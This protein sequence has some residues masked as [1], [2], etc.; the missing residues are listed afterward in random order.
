MKKFRQ[1]LTDKNST[2][3]KGVNNHLSLN[4]FNSFSFHIK[5]LDNK[6]ASETLPGR[7]GTKRNRIICSS[8][9]ECAC[10]II[11]CVAVRSRTRGLEHLRINRWFTR[12]GCAVRATTTIFGT[13]ERL[14]RTLASITIP[15]PELRWAL[16]V[17]V[18]R[19]PGRSTKTGPATAFNDHGN[20]VAINKADV[21]KILP[22][23]SKSELSQSYRRCSSESV[24]FHLT[25]P[26]VTC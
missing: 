24:A 15:N 9:S 13:P 5:S 20:I 11:V 23:C 19:T 1:N 22:S 17:Q 2:D 14:T 10:S 26:T 18:S 3:K 8:T 25:R 4:H 6:N 7:R 16:P 12:G 21:I